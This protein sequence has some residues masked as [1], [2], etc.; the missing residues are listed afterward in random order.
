[1]LFLSFWCCIDARIPNM[2]LMF[3]MLQ[4]IMSALAVQQQQQ[5]RE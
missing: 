3:V 1:M 5:Q 2:S 4:D